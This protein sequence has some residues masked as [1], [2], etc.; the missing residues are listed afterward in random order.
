MDMCIYNT[1]YI[2]TYLKLSNFTCFVVFTYTTYI[3]HS[4]EKKQTYPSMI[5]RG[6]SDIHSQ[7]FGNSNMKAHVMAFVEL[8]HRS[9]DGL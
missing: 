1:H 8:K 6:P 9:D 7:L 4:I 5:F 3:Q 2:L